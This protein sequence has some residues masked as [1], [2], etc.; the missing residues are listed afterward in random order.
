MGLKNLNH[1][2]Q[3]VELV[4]IFIVEMPPRMTYSFFR[5]NVKLSDFNNYFSVG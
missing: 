3:T 5:S 2:Q 1:S 4:L